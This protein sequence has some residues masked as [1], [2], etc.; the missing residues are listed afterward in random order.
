M[1]VVLVQLS[2]LDRWV[3]ITQCTIYHPKPDLI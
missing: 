2:G 1:L 3:K